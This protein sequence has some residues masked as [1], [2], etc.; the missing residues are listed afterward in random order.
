MAD[1]DDLAPSYRRAQSRWPDAPSLSKHYAALAGCFAGGG[2]GL[3]EHVK[4]FI[5]CVCVTI[6][7]E[8]REP[9]P[10]S[11]PTTTDLLVA[12][13]SPLGLRNTKGASKL[14]KVL[15]GFNRLSDALAEMRNETGPVAHGK[16][17]FLDAVTS[18]HARAFLAVG[19]AILGL[20]LNALEG[21]EPDL[22]A[23]REPYENFPHLN[24]RIDRAV[25]VEARVDEDGG[26]PVVVL[27]VATG[28]RAEAIELRV[29]PSRLLYGIDRGAYIE[30]L[31]TAD[32]VVAAM[33]EE[34][35]P[36][37]SPTK[38]R[39]VSWAAPEVG[40]RTVLLLGYSGALDPYRPG[41][42]G[43]LGA[44]VLEAERVDEAGNRLIDSLLA[45]AEQ[46]FGLDWTER[47]PIQARLKVA[48][49]RAL[50]HFGVDAGKADGIAGRLV[51]WVRV[52]VGSA[53]AAGS[54]AN[55]AKEGS[56]S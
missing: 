51:A 24:E 41:L 38:A 17:G 44:E 6:M 27:S 18:D 40:P 21:K 15:S 1:L 48:F 55:V 19:D 2:Y 56:I 34:E 7:G 4:S 9:M 26:R 16:D 10:S 31:R 12:A 52:Q 11:T 45:T 53:G 49:K 14:D 20:L 25:S 23:T 8:L 37:A 54:G 13:L 47:E 50:V 3:V 28:S 33:E 30:V 5:E 32:L 39:E 35:A 43:F 46:N 42:D 36:E 29:E 22:S